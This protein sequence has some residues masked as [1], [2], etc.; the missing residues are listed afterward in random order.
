MKPPSRIAVL[1]AAALALCAFN[2]ALVWRA[3]ERQLENTDTSRHSRARG[4]RDRRPRRQPPTAP[5]PSTYNSTLDVD[6]VDP[7]KWHAYRILRDAGISPITPEIIA[8]L[9]RWSDIVSQF[10]PEPIL[11]LDS[12]AAYRSS[13][14]PHD[15]MAAVAG[16]F[17]TGTN[18][19]AH[20][21]ADNCQIDRGLN[22][23]G[24]GMRMQVVSFP[25]NRDLRRCSLCSIQKKVS[26]FR[27]FS[28]GENTIRPPRIA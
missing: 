3:L 2:V 12:C 16:L 21:M 17:N 4:P 11:N 10:G 25:F 22:G 19:L 7:E 6:D 9:P 18:L 15:R 5:P 8:R 20:L 27:Y 1:L 24:T 28:R 13:V 26:F 14:P 23:T